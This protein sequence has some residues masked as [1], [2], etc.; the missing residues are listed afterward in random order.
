MEKI[1]KR[2]HYFIVLDTETC[3]TPKV[4]NKL[5]V[6][7][8]LVYDIG[9]SVVDTKGNTYLSRSYVVREIIRDYYPLFSSS[10]YHKKIPNYILDIGDGKRILA[11]FFT[12]RKIFFNDCAKYDIK[13]VCAHN[14]RFDIS[15]LNSTMRALTNEERKYF[16]PYGME[17][18]DSVKMARAVVHAM[19]TYNKFCEDNDLKTKT[20]KLPTTAEALYKFITNN[21]DFQEA[22]TALE[23]VE[24]EKEIVFYCY[25]QHKPMKKVLYAGKA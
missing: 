19:P 12:I 4:D 18:W 8:G 17:V 5:D 7:K 10:Y 1:D 9:W 16:L 22:H 13:E 25:R 6:S 3:N 24:I 21:P 11:S 20:N 14:A 2:K 23:D 15:V